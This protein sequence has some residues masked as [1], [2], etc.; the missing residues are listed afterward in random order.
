MCSGASD[1][2]R[3]TSTSSAMTCRPCPPSITESPHRVSP[4][5]TPITRTPT[6]FCEHLFDGSLAWLTDVTWE[7]HAPGEQGNSRFL[8]VESAR[9]MSPWPAQAAPVALAHHSGRGAAIPDDVPRGSPTRIG[10][11]VFAS[12]ACVSVPS[13]RRPGRTGTSLI[14]VSLAATAACGRVLRRHPRRRRGAGAARTREPVVGA[15]STEITLSYVVVTADRDERTAACCRHG[16][17]SR[18]SR[19]VPLS[20][21][22]L[23]PDRQ[24]DRQ[25]CLHPAP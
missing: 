6:T 8:Q 19:P 17:P 23:R 21:V 16:H 5:S 15:G 10:T 3:T 14:A 22:I 1:G 12:A 9:P 20:Q 4:G 18:A 13:S 24:R 7:G 25:R 2:V 11:T